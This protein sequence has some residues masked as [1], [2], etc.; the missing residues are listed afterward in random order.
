MEAE[1]D[2]VNMANKPT[3]DEEFDNLASDD[4][5]ENELA[6]IKAAQSNNRREAI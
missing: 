5:I 4:E 1:A 6:K 2:L 3:I